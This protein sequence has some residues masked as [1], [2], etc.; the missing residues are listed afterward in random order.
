MNFTEAEKLV[1]DKG[2]KFVP[3]RKLNTFSTFI[4]I[5]KYMGKLNVQ[6]YVASNPSRP[7]HLQ[8][9]SHTVHSGL[10]NPLLFNPPV[11]TAS[12]IKV[13]RDLVLKDLEDLPNKRTHSD[14]NI[15][16]GLKSL[17]ERKDLIICPTDKGG[18]VVILD[19]SDYHGEMTRILS[20]TETYCRLSK[21]PTS[22][23]K[24]ILVDLVDSGFQ[25][26]IL[27][28]KEKNYLVPVV[29]RIPIIYYLPKVH[30][31]VTHPPGRPIIS[32]INSVTSRIGKYIDFFLQPIVQSIPS[33]LKDT[34][35]TIAK[36][37]QI[38]Y[39]DDLLLVTADVT[40]LYTCIPQEL[41]LGAVE[42]FLFRD[43][44]IPRTQKRF[45]MDLL[46]FATSSNYFWYNNQFYLQTKGVAMG[47]KFVWQTF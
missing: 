7:S 47:A 14:P 25:L 19:K 11:P 6:R 23:Y 33:F 10:T 30:K 39:S 37:Q 2:L 45:I 9:S 22:E 44:I 28:K 18:G 29:P 38:T 46:R 27:D 13:F 21:N 40:S 12:S 31:N 32:G 36:L 43:K 1:L 35:D 8:I 15:K 42:L 3:P 16:I 41:G 24:K 34:R 17:C 20:D 26:G 4:D 5:H